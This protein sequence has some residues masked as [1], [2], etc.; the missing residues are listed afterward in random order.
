MPVEHTYCPVVRPGPIDVPDAVR[1][2]ARA[3]GAIGAQWLA[4]LPAIFEELERRWDMAVGATLSGGT[5]G[6][7]AEATMADGT[8]AVVKVAIIFNNGGM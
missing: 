1:I 8:A 6:C 3:H 2:T 7:V 4:D 5:A